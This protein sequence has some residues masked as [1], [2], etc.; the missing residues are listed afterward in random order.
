[1]RSFLHASYQESVV[2]LVL[3]LP[4]SLT[5]SVYAPNKAM[6]N[7]L[8][9]LFFQSRSL[10]MAV[11]GTVL[12]LSSAYAPPSEDLRRG[13]SLRE[14]TGAF[15]KAPEL[16]LVLGAVASHEF[17]TISLD[18]LQKSFWTLWCPWSLAHGWIWMPPGSRRRSLAFF[19]ASHALSALHFTHRLNKAHFFQV[20]QKA[21]LP[22][23]SGLPK[24]Q[25]TP[26]CTPPGAT[27]QRRASRYTSSQRTARTRGRED[28][29][30]DLS[31]GPTSRH[32]PL[33]KE[34]WQKWCFFPTD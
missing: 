29:T 28:V 15:S 21:V 10:A 23:G 16:E 26:G 4:I 32:S 22:F 19:D 8:F 30:S 11:P 9:A 25:K 18:F 7:A 33:W 12:V 20:D 3:E 13:V 31:W 24:L 17:L 14:C 1:M 2:Y 6:L 27:A 34:A 5:K